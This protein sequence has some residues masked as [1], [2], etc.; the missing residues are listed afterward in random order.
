M[1]LIVTTLLA[2]EFER[3]IIAGVPEREGD[4]ENKTGFQIW[5]T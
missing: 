3:D 2:A 5:K 1:G 4:S